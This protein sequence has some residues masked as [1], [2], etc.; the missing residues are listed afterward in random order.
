VYLLLHGHSDVSQRARESDV[1]DIWL[2][3]ASHSRPPLS[4]FRIASM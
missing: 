4:P 1:S 2:A 3:N